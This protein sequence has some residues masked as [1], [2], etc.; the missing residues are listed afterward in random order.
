MNNSKSNLNQSL[1]KKNKPSPNEVEKCKVVMS[2]S[3]LMPMMDIKGIIIGSV[4][5]LIP[6]IVLL[7]IVC[8]II[9]I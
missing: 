6:W 1:N 3:E 2:K 7:L 9:V 8:G 5:T 4:G